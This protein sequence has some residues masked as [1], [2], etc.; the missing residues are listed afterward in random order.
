ML[1]GTKMKAETG[2]PRVID[3]HNLHRD[4]R[5]KVTLAAR[6]LLTPVAR[7]YVNANMVYSLEERVFILENFLVLKSFASVREAFSN[8]YPDKKVP[9]KT[10]IHRLVTKFRDTDSIRIF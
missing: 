8:A 3:T 5:A 4:T 7:K 1:Y 10:T 2:P 9:N 6:P